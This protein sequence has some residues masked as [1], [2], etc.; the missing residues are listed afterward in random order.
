MPKGEYLT[1][2]IKLSPD[3]AAIVGKT[4]S[5]RAEL[6]ELLW[7]YLKNNNLQIEGDETFFVPDDKMAKVFGKKPMRV[8]SMAKHYRPHLSPIKAKNSKKESDDEIA[9]N[10]KR[11]EDNLDGAAAAAD[12]DQVS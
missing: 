12:S 7:A 3:L 4:E 5:S 1:K 8:Y 6:M 10:F 11:G 2:S 9:F